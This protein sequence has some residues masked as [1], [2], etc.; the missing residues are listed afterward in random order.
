MDLTFQPIKTGDIPK[1]MPF[2]SMRPNK[3]CDSIFLESYIW[4]AYYNV[5][6]AIWEDRAL[7][8]LMEM[9]GHMFSAMPLCRPEDLPDA[10]AA[11]E[12]YFNENLGFPLVINLAD[13]DAINLLQLPADRYLVEEQLD[14]RDYLYDGEAL[15]TLSGKKLHK[16]KNRLNVFKRNYEGRYEYRRLSCADGAAVRDFLDKWREGRDDGE[17]G[18]HLDYEAEGVYDILMNCGMIPCSMGGVFIDGKLEAF[19]IGGYN[20]LEKMAVIPIEKANPEIDG[21]YQFINQEFLLDAFPEAVL[22]NRE[23][24]VG[25]EGLR[26]AKLSYNP[27][28]Y[29]RKF[30]VQQ[31]VDGQKGYHWAERIENTTAGPA[32]AYL[33]GDDRQV[34]RPLY[35]ACFPEDSASFTDYYYAEKVKDNR[36]LV[37][38]DNGLIM[39]MTHLNPYTADFRGKELQ[40]DYLVAVATSPERQREGHYADLFRELLQDQLEEGK[41]FT[42]LVPVNPDVYRPF[43]FTF[44]GDVCSFRLTEDAEKRLA[45]RTCTDSKEDLAAA[46]EYMERWLSARAELHTR[47]DKAYVRRML[48]E[49][50]SEEGTLE[51]LCDGETVVGL[52]AEWGFGEREVRLLYADGPYVEE[53]GKKPWSM[54]R[55][56]DARTLFTLFRK[57][58]EEPDVLAELGAGQEESFYDPDEDAADAGEEEGV[59]INIRIADPILA[60]NN[61]T[62]VWTLTERGAS[63]VPADEMA[64]YGE[65]AGASGKDADNGENAPESVVE[66]DITVTPEE[67]MS[68]LFGRES[69]YRLWPDAGVKAFTLLNQVDIINGV[70]LDE[71]V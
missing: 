27:A 32:L 59:V 40:L 51:F 5:Q 44:V 58:P 24:D 17:G 43:G 42:W 20:E 62:F 47:R 68:W 65:H 16:K 19:T 4:K 30:L 25:L 69:M 52:Y 2:Y 23:D 64:S 13:E 39:S 26:Q 48:K 10:F 55:V 53:T 12:R 61:R 54:A 57:K 7:L 70:Y 41:P 60:E 9:D 50:A 1:M 35:E 11:I 15:R 3:T 49:L 67:L 66:P 63:A 71:L 56:T 18:A 33:E 37:K 21:I 45:R 8:W 6:Y 38:K 34:T 29:A 22:V 14:A 31:L 28:G 36:V 46:A